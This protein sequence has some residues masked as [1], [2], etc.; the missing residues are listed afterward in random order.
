MLS[1]EEEFLFAARRETIYWKLSWEYKSG[2]EKKTEY[3]PSKAIESELRRL[4]YNDECV[5]YDFW[6]GVCVTCFQSLAKARKSVSMPPKLCRRGI[7][8]FLATTIDAR[9]NA[10]CMTKLGNIL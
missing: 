5:L 7:S 8:S 1:T 9:N 2:L 4:G 6:K 3:E 10:S